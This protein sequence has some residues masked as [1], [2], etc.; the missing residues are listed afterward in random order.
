[1][2]PARVP[3]ALNHS[4]RCT[5]TRVLL[6]TLAGRGSEGEADLELVCL[7]QSQPKP[8]PAAQVRKAL[9]VYLSA[10]LLGVHPSYA[11]TD[12]QQAFDR[13]W[14][15]NVR[16]AGQQ[17]RRFALRTRIVW[18]RVVPCVPDRTRVWHGG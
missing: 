14:P 1:M 12:A 13:A 16:H 4:Q 18:D 10:M 6:S 3:E 11:G 8:V 15:V 17:V 2:R 7:Q 9:K 5:A